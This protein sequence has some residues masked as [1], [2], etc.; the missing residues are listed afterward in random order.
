MYAQQW[1]FQVVV[2]WRADSRGLS[3]DPASDLFPLSNP[4]SVNV[5][6][7][8]DWLLTNRTWHMMGLASESQLCY[9][10]FY[11]ASKLALLDLLSHASLDET[12]DN[13]GGPR[14]ET[15][16]V[17]FKGSGWPSVSSEQKN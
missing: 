13:V 17:A 16:Q 4:L 10:S 7:A 1:N 11:L 6:G 2:S 14:G 9:T 15:W 12:T 8:C 3:K 5:G